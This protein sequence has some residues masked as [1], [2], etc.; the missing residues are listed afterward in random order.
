MLEFQ[1]CWPL[2]ELKGKFQV[3]CVQEKEK[4]G[5]HLWGN[6]S[7]TSLLTFQGPPSA[8]ITLQNAPGSNP[9]AGSPPLTRLQTCFPAN[10][11]TA[12]SAFLPLKGRRKGKAFGDLSLGLIS[13]TTPGGKL[14]S[15]SLYHPQFCA[16]VISQNNTSQVALAVQR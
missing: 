2:R 15:T 11:C 14:H 8:A 9:P 1:C 3:T 5:K 12:R 7:C 16:W 6:L 13:P 4:T 10:S